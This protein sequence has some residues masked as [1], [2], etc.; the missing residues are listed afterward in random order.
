MRCEEEGEEGEAKRRRRLCIARDVLSVGTGAK[1]TK[2][3]LVHCWAASGNVLDP[4]DKINNG[5]LPKIGRCM[6]LR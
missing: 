1:G 5:S 6:C 3:L 4:I 2:A